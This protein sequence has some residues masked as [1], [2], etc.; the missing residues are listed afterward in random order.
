MT[1]YR[2]KGGNEYVKFIHKIFDLDLN[3]STEKIGFYDLKLFENLDEMIF[4]IKE[5][6]NQ[7]GL[8]RMVAGFAWE[9][10]SKKDKTLND[11]EINNCQ[12]KWNSVDKDWVNSPN[13]INEVGCIHTTQG[14]DLNFTGVIIG[15]ELDYDFTLNKFV[16]YK[17]KYKDKNGK[18]S[19]TDQNILLEYVINIYKTILLRGIEGTYIYVCNEN[20]RK[21]LSNY[22]PIFSKKVENINLL[23]ILDE[24]NE[25]T[26]PYYNL[27]IA[28]GNFSEYQNLDEIKYIEVNN[29][30]NRDDYFICKVVGES[31]NKIIPN[32]SLCI[33]KKYFGGSR[34]GL[35]TLVE[36][37]EI[38]D[39]DYGGNYTI[40]EYSSK[41]TTDANGWK[42]EEIILKPNSTK[43]YNPIVLKDEQTIDFKVI[44]IFEKIL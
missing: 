24:P 30:Q 33:F 31:M 28:A 38:S 41:K 11:I 3:N 13:A 8:S 15:P 7:V 37:T 40:K 43:N 26:I 21:Y 12:L 14:Y 2:V 23:K 34:N 42:H 1:Q 6:E 5:K 27:E 10:I 29:L 19:I 36:S 4:Q 39:I 18:N 22:I 25:F 32:G 17:D 35:I 16:V 44:G 20:L 9:W